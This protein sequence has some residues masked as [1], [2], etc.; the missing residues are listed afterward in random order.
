MMRHLR[1]IVCAVLAMVGMTVHAQDFTVLDWATMRIDSVLPVYTEVVPLESD[2]QLYDY[3]VSIEYPEWKEL[4]SSET[5]VANAFADK[6]SDAIQVESQVGVSRRQGVLDISFVPIVREGAKY[7]KLLSAKIVI[8]PVAKAKQ[9]LAEGGQRRNAASRATGKDRF[10]RNSVLSSGRWVKISI[11]EDGMYRLTADALRQ[12]GFGNPENVHLYGCGGHRMSEVMDLNK[13]YDDLQEVPMYHTPGSGVWYFWGN[14]LVYW[15]GDKRI[16]NPYANKAYYFLTE[17]SAPSK[18]ETEQAVSG[19]VR[20]TYKTTPAHSLYEVD[21]FSWFHGGRNLYDAQNFGSS[22]SHRRNY[23]MQSFNAVGNERLTVSFSG[24]STVMTPTVNN[25]ALASVTLGEPADFV[26]TRVVNKTYNVSNCKTGDNVWNITLR[27]SNDKDARLDYL[28]L[29]YDRSLSLVNGY[30]PFSQTGS[31][32]STFE[33]S[34][35]ASTTK[36][37]RVSEPGSPAVLIPTE[38]AGNGVFK[39]TVDDPRKQY[40]A[41]DLQ[42]DFPVPQYEGEVANQNLHALDK[43]D[44]VIIVPASCKLAAEAERLAEAHRAYDGMKVAVVNAE[45]VYNEFSSGTPDATAYRMLMKMLYDRAQDDYDGPRYLLLMGACIW[46]NRMLT[47]ATK[48]L[49]PNDFL[50]CYESENSWNDTESFVMEDY[51]GLL[52]DGEGATLTSDKVDLGIGRFPVKSAAEAKI[53]V[54]KCIQFMSNSNAGSWKNIVLMLGDDGDANSHMQYCDDV[55]E[56]IISRSPEMEVRKVMWDAYTRVSTTTNNSYP[57]VTKLIT[58]Q[59][60]DGVMMVNYTGHAA[61]YSLSHEFVLRLQNFQAFKGQNLPLW[62]TAGCDVMPFD[63]QSDNLGVTAVLNDGGAA[64]AFIGTARTVYASNNRSLNLN[65]SEYIFGKDKNGQRN[66]VGDALRMAK[67]A[68]IGKEGFHLENKLQYALLGDPAL[69]IGAPLNRVHLDG[70]FDA[71]T[72]EQ[73]DQLKAGQAV[74]LEGSLLDMNGE[75]I[76]DFNGILTARVYDSK[77]TIVC[78]MND[79]QINTAFTFTDRSQVLF[80]GR[81]SVRLGRFSLSFIVPRD[82]K[83]SNGAG[84]VVF[85]AINDT[86]RVEANG[87][88][89]DF[90]VGGAVDSEDGEG[91][92]IELALN[93]EYGGTVNSTPYLTARLNDPNGINVNGIG[94]GHDLLLC[95]DGD[96][97]QTYVLNDYYSPDFGD[98]SSGSLAFTIPSLSPGKHTLTLRAWDLLNNTSTQSMDFEVDATY[99]PTIL[100]LMASP[101]IARESTTF[102]LTYDLPG[103]QSEYEIEVF[104]YSGRCLWRYEGQ[105]SSTGTFAIPWNLTLGDGHGRLFPGVYLYRAS[106][107]CGDSK[108]VTKSH[109]LIVN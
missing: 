22:S 43:I 70:I 90:T 21:D 32:I 14:G 72:G 93:G 88:N 97:R 10:T 79:P 4:T 24:F 19:T 51:F 67:V 69:T 57:E 89:E 29:H 104:D 8:N 74:R 37:M 45:Q 81:D 31:G 18:I 66:R 101:T 62:F 35:N 61:P 54:D 50:L 58:Q 52:D 83:Y 102:F 56:R 20:Q 86:K 33:I 100:N 68:L 40:V 63:S 16:F 41:F 80:A 95:V 46:D 11:A 47:S 30:L 105:G 3:R 38:N 64:L 96:A 23:R 106:L 65:F 76:K 87:Y 36:V 59:V 99:A 1:Y 109:K 85:Y 48:T 12:M 44:M 6:I 27:T 2:F 42:Y 78:N 53:M 34:G 107:K 108:V 5:K 7:K 71:N 92:Q 39:V 84:R 94:M 17:E 98:Y 49:D 13:I 91:P 73:I 77:D 26:Y 103:T 25:T 9:D 55:A 15:E 75:Q 28:A 60:N 82:I